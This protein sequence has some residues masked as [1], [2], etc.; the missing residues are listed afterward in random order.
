M[1]ELTFNPINFG[2][3]WTDDWYEFDYT[4]ARAE[5]K[6]QRNI[7]AAR[8]RKAGCRVIT[9]SQS[10]CLM[11][12]GGIGSGHPHIEEVVTVYGILYQ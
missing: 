3:R 4:A 12:M 10:G 11:S 6:R 1:I 2:F 7:E 5:A 9:S 8:L